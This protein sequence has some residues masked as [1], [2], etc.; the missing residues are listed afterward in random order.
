MSI[1][2]YEE[3]L[4]ATDVSDIVYL[5]DREKRFEAIRV[6]AYGPEEEL[7]AFEVYLSD[8]LQ[9]PFKA[10]WRDPDELGHSE[11]VVVLGAL[12]SDDRCGVFLSV[13]RGGKKRRIVAEQIWANDTGVNAT[14][15]DDYRY[16]VEHDGIP[17]NFDEDW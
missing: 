15:L 3:G 8:T 1:S 7:V 12:G 14:A 4:F 10:T 6:N 2:H 5:P 9:T 11:T 16:W 17:S 13:K